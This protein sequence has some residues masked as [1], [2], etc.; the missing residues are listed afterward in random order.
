MPSAPGSPRWSGSRGSCKSRVFG[1]FCRWRDR[2]V[3]TR[4]N[5]RL[6]IM[7]RER[8]GGE[9]SPSAAVLDSQS[10]PRGYD[11][12]KKIKGRKRQAMVDMDGRALVLD[13]Q[14][15]D[16]QDRDGAVPVLRLSRKSF[17]FVAKAFADMG[18]SGDRPQMAR[19][20]ISR[21]SANPRTR[22][23][24]PFIQSGGLLNASSP[25]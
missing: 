22:S 23:A 20:S 9:A 16:V 25:G 7:D 24:L 8:T 4:I 2:G 15:A 11:A 18:Y 13:P 17:P 19:L 10:G 12:G 5:H 6:V 1:Y 3:F 21:S 14:P